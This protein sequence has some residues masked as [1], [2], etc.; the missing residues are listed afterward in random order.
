MSGAG[1]LILFLVAGRLEVGDLSV[2]SSTTRLRAAR[3]RARI[4]A[5]AGNDVRGQSKTTGT[6]RLTIC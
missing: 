3:R 6:L 1:V 2:A 5:L 4:S